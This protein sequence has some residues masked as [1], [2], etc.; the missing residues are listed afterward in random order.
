MSVV[1][2]A[3]VWVSALLPAE[4]QHVT[5]R[6]WFDH[7]AASDGLLVEPILLLAE[8]AGAIARR[9]DARLAEQTI[10]KLQRLSTIRL[11]PVDRVIGQQ[12]VRLASAQRLRG[13]DAIYVA[14]AYHLGIPLVT[15]DEEQR[16]RAGAVITILTP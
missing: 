4:T 7:Y 15:W 1:V 5:S 11:V 2:D 14:L 3:S 12:A 8:V 16:T 10:D 13:A 6:Q 9:S